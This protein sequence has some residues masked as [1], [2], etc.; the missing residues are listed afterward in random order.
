[1]KI[2]SFVAAL[3]AAALTFAPA[4]A[5]AENLRIGVEGAYPPFSAVDEKR[6]LNRF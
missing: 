5:L 1:M 3:G 6:R 2:K 4:P